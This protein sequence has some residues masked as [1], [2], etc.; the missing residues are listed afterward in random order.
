M[1][2]IS[3]CCMRKTYKSIEMFLHRH[4]YLGT[5]AGGTKPTRKNAKDLKQKKTFQT[6]Q[7]CS[8]FLFEISLYDEKKSHV[9]GLGSPNIISEKIRSPIIVSVPEVEIK[10]A[11]T[12]ENTQSYVINSFTRLSLSGMPRENLKI[13]SS[14]K[15]GGVQ[16]CIN[17]FVSTSYTI[18]DVFFVHLKG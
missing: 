15:R 7:I 1:K 11:I 12:Q 2:C 17:R 3:R 9:K 6:T 16:R 10:C 8:C 18:A 13:L 4:I 5:G 14:Q